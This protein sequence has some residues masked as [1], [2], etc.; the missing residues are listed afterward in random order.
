[1]RSDPMKTMQNC[2]GKCGQVLAEGVRRSA[3]YSH[4]HS[5]REQQRRRVRC[6]CGC[7]S[8]Y[9]QL[10]IPVLRNVLSRFHELTLCSD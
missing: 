2:F 10:F 3:L 9:V 5:R 6:S 8:A 1:M 7:Y 4:V